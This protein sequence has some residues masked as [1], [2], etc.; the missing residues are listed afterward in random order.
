MRDYARSVSRI[1]Q[2]RYERLR[3]RLYEDVRELVE[4]D[5]A[6][7]QQ[8]F[9]DQLGDHGGIDINEYLQTFR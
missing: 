3:Q 2:V 6:P 8:P 4:G 7:A 9:T 1:M 5:H